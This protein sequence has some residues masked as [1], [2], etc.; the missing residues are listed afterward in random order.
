V[1]LTVTDMGNTSSITKPAFISSVPGAGLPVQVDFESGAFPADWICASTNGGGSC[2]SV[3]DQ[4]SGF[5]LGTYSMAFDNFNNDVQGARDEEWLGKLSFVGA[6]SPQLTFDVAYARYDA[7][8]S[9]SLAVRVSTD[10]GD[11]WTEVYVKG[12]IALA[13]APDQQ[14]FFVPVADQWRTEMVDLL[15]FADEPQVIIAFQN[16][17]R[18]GNVIRVDNINLVADAHSNVQESAQQPGVSV[19][20]IPANDVLNIRV[21]GSSNGMMVARILDA[22]GRE[23]LNDALLF[24]ANGSAQRLV[25][26]SLSPGNYTLKLGAQAIPFIVL[27]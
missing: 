10:C 18:F 13:T 25:V 15:A 19:F 16:R 26:R 22:T 24:G 20:P 9:D 8:Y 27:R 1:S 14:E 2:W 3:T 11:T 7:Q 17:G 23:V 5:G 4:A 21:E 12:G 6:V